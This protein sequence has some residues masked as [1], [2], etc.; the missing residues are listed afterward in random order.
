MSKETLI[1]RLEKRAQI[2]TRK[3][4]QEGQPDRIA[5]LLEEA[6]MEIRV[7]TERLR[8]EQ[9]QNDN[10]GVDV[11]CDDLDGHV[12]NMTPQPLVAVPMHPVNSSQ[13]SYIGHDGDDLFVKFHTNDVYKY[14]DV[15]YTT[16]QKMLQAES[17]CGFLNS[18]IK[19]RFS[20]EKVV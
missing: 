15:P 17:V 12:F 10:G 4:V 7:L 6:A 11:W 3:S 14:R 2:Q 20:Y 19:N 9:E 5:D 1:T 16:F 13:I 8:L 18:Q